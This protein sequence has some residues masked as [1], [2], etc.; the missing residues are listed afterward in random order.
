VPYDFKALQTLFHEWGEQMS[1]GGGWNAIFWNNHDQPRALNRFVDIENYHEKG[2]TML[3]A[4]IHLSR[5]TPYI[6]MGEEIGMVD[7]VYE[8]MADYVDIES[9]NAYQMLLDQGKTADEA[10]EI[11]QIKS[12]DNSRIPM[13]WSD[14][15]NGGF[16]TG[17]PWLKSGAYHRVNVAKDQSGPIF[18]FYQ[19]L[20]QLRKSEAI[21]SDGS[22]Q[23]AYQDSEHVYAFIRE[24]GNQKMLVLNNFANQPIAIDVLSEFK[25]AEV[26]VNNYDNFDGQY[27]QPHQSVAL[28]ITF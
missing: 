28:R 23:A 20:I 15:A 7:P 6:Y 24:H 17:T 11:I 14:E 18:K 12:R 26:F 2:A 8:S 27:L 4:S 21:I 1:E 9:I 19:N 13:Q 25:D 10:F 3:A 5:G 22:Y 16:T